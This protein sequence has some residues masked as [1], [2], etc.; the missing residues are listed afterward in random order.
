MDPARTLFGVLGPFVAWQETT[1]GRTE[2]ALGPPRQRAVLAGLVLRPGRVVDVD[3]L[4][5]DVWGDA[6]PRGG[7][8]VVQ[9]Y[10]SALRRVLEPHRAPRS[11]AGILLSTK[12]GYRLDVEPGRVDAFQAET[13]LE[14]ARTQRDVE[15]LSD[16]LRLWRGTPLAGLPGPFA[17]AQRTRY[18]ELRA[19]VLEEYYEA[20]LAEGRRGNEIV[21]ELA[22]LVEEHPLR[23]RLRALLMRA[24][25]RD[26]RRADALAVFRQGRRFLVD[27]QGVEPGREL[28]RL[29]HGI[30]AADSDPTIPRQLPGPVH[31]FT[32]RRKELTQLNHLLRP[33]PTVPIAAVVG[34]AGVGKTSLV[35]QWAHNN[36]ERFPDGQLFVDLRG[37]GQ[38]AGRRP[39]NVL[40]ALLTALGVPP[41]RIPTEPDDAQVLLRTMLANRRM[42][43]VLDNARSPYDVRLLLPGSATVTVIVTSRD[44]L[45]GLVAQEGARRVRLEP[46][47]H[48][49]SERLLQR[50]LGRADQELAELCGHLPLALRIAAANLAP[51]AP[52]AADDYLRRLRSP[53]RLDALRVVGDDQL[54]TGSA[55][56]A[57]YDALPPDAA[58]VFGLL[59]V[60]PGEDSGLAAIAALIGRDPTETERVLRVLVGRH[61]LDERPDGRYVLHDLMRDFANRLLDP[62]ERRRALERCLDYYL[63]SVGAALRFVS[64]G[65]IELPAPD[66]RV[67][68]ER[69]DSEAVALTWFDAEVRNL[70]DAVSSARAAGLDEH[71]WRL[72][73]APVT[74][75][76]MRGRW[77]DWINTHEIALESARRLG[78][79]HV[80]AMTIT[81]MAYAYLELD[82]PEVAL[83][84]Y[85]RATDGAHGDPR[86]EAAANEGMAPAYRKLGDTAAAMRVAHR[87]LAL[88]HDLDDRLGACN[89]LTQIAL[90]H[91]ERGE[92]ERSLEYWA[93]CLRIRRDAD[94]K[95]GEGS[96]LADL[97]ETFRQAG[98]P[99]EA[100]RHMIRAV[101]LLGEVG[102]RQNQAS[103]LRDLGRVCWDLDD[104]D[105]ARA[106]W[107]Q[108]LQLYEDADSSAAALVRTLLDGATR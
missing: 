78:D 57:S 77:H 79:P 31:A 18:S 32:G 2:V 48:D 108:A 12:D 21:G 105:A 71:A 91:R 40:T 90:A 7:A 50:L 53:D 14:Q 63:H 84:W 54:A 42:L 92:F 43:L 46:L 81:S 83:T 67:T 87:A 24:L 28:Q 69:F 70:V 26:G 11:R 103:A 82:R 1:D 33:G 73:R 76:Q 34:P 100:H 15:A 3:E 5:V 85:Q 58:A 47:R 96:T 39:E 25:D 86:I 51:L 104:R 102:H 13:R 88:Y 4:V 74:L 97:G 38:D 60:P 44:E 27:R 95:L 37:F 89:A 45:A 98:R 65:W 99:A 10:I 68:P 72:A 59:D 29:H 56:R 22:A 8:N 101:S 20:C 35:V 41:S 23:E 75:F 19:A 49:E 61:L 9:T 36:L 106:H 80:E 66:N 107:Q 64:P 52:A 30:L 16:I 94:F 17:S 55:F 93:Q 62:P 6:A